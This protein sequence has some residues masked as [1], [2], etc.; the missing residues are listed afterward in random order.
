MHT[1][2]YTIALSYILTR[3]ALTS[4][5]NKTSDRRRERAWIAVSGL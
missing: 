4:N 1:T 5:E 3:G 2:V